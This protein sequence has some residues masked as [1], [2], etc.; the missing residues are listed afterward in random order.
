M[1]PTEQGGI[2]YTAGFLDG[3]GCITTQRGSIRVEVTN[4]NLDVLCFLQGLWGG[5]VSTQGRPKAGY[6]QKWQIGWYGEAGA[7]LLRLCLPY[8]I[9]KGREAVVALEIHSLGQ[10]THTAVPER[11]R[12]RR[13][14]LNTLLKS[15]K[16]D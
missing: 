15:L 4:T 3:E 12:L 14:V 9:V 1:Q 2:I 7:H 8:L 10:F 16:R 5:K 11:I 13:E 6:R